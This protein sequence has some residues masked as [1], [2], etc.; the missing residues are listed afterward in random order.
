MMGTLFQLLYIF[1]ISHPKKLKYINIEPLNLASGH[2]R[3]AG[4][5]LVAETG[6]DS[7]SLESTDRLIQET[8][9]NQIVT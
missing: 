2:V 7:A 3:G 4:E 9:M 1:E 5:T 8:E 6:S